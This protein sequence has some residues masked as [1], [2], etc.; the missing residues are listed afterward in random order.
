MSITLIIIILTCLI[1]ISAFSNIKM[2]GDLLFYPPS[3]AAQNQYYRFI[4]HGFVHADYLHLA[5]NMI[6][7]YFFGTAVEEKLFEDPC[8]FGKMGKL[9]Y[10]LLY[11]TAIIAACIPDYIRHRNNTAYASLG[12]SGAISAIIFAAIVLLPK[13]E[14]FLMFIPIGIP[15][16]IFGPVFLL[17]SAY[18]DKRGG[19]N[20]AHG[21]HFWGAMY[22][23]IFTVIAV[24]VGGN[25][26]VWDNFLEQLRAPSYFLPD[27]D[28]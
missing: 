6:A 11:L 1:S 15:G 25:I 23:I 9:V 18:L 26:N 27:C 2:K 5:F 17:I 21:A 16:Y 13:M 14:I 22:G 3:I 7:L 8:F 4:T 24:N 28:L 10:A 12:A 20:V 19:G